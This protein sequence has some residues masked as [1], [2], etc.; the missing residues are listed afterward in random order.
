MFRGCRKLNYIKMLAT[1]IYANDCLYNWVSGVASSG[2]FVKNKDAT[3][4]VAGVDGVPS[5][6]TI[7]YE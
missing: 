4:N 6:W 1:D 5:G 7:V 2:T 3:W